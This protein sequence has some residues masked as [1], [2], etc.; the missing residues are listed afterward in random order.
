VTTTPY[1]NGGVGED[2]AAVMRSRA[3]DFSMRIMFAEGSNYDFT[4]DVP[5]VIADARGNPIFALDHAGPLLYVMLPKGTY[6]VTAQVNDVAEA[7]H[8]TLDG[9][10]AEDVVL[11]WNP[12]SDSETR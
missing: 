9:T 5:V 7:R 1:L 6:T 8:V 11:H 4:A 2:E 3:D 12:P 10:H